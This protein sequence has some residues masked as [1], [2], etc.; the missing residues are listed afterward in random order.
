MYLLGQGEHGEAEEEQPEDSQVNVINNPDHDFASQ[1]L[2]RQ[3]RGGR[4]GQ[5][6]GGGRGAGL[7]QTEE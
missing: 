1:I 7:P 6:R 5:R 3:G 2:R 4:L